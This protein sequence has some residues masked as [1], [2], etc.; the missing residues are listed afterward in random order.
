V[1][2]ANSKLLERVDCDDP[3]VVA[4]IDLPADLERLP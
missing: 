1:L 2:F 4:D 3:G